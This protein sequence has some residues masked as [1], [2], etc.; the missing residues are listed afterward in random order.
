[1][2][3][4]FSNVRLPGDSGEGIDEG[5]D[6]A[7]VFDTA[8]LGFKEEIIEGR[9]ERETDGDTEEVGFVDGGTD[10]DEDGATV[11]LGVKDVADFAIVGEVE[12]RLVGTPIGADSFATASNLILYESKCHAFGIDLLLTTVTSSNMSIGSLELT[13]TATASFSIRVLCVMPPTG[14]DAHLKLSCPIDA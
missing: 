9:P 6:S 7:G 14:R 8:I 1:V 3:S 2:A 4:P 13:T 5:S 11:M 10:A 12:G